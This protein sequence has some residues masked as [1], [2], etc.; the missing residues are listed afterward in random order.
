MASEIF[1]CLHY[2]GARI[3][4][5]VPEKIK[6]RNVQKMCLA[7]FI[8]LWLIGAKLKATKST[9]TQQSVLVYAFC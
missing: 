4:V 5:L 6:D 1:V 7:A 8:L 2:F 3:L 9:I